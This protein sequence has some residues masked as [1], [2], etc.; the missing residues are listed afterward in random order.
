MRNFG[1][2]SYYTSLVKAHLVNRYLILAEASQ[3]S[4]GRVDS[5]KFGGPQVVSFRNME[6]Q[7]QV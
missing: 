2:G 1:I 7:F 5:L 6:L 3:T 4:T